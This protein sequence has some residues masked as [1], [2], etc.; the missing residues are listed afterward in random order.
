MVCYVFLYSITTSPLFIFYCTFIANFTQYLAEAHV[1]KL[2]AEY[3]SFLVLISRNKAGKIRYKYL[4]RWWMPRPSD[5]ALRKAARPNVY[6]NRTNRNSCVHVVVSHEDRSYVG[7]SETGAGNW[8]TCDLQPHR[9]E[10]CPHLCVEWV[11]TTCRWTRIKNN[12][13]SAGTCW[14]FHN[15]QNK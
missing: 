9:L 11:R 2:I 6:T 14:D 5:R 15:S 12:M 10:T 3:F 4:P 1:S 8:L 7:S 13:Q